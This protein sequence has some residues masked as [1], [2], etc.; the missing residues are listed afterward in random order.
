M[1]QKLNEKFFLTVFAQI[2]IVFLSSCSQGDL[3]IKKTPTLQVQQQVQEEKKSSQMI[4][5]EKI[6]R[7]IS[8]I[9]EAKNLDELMKL[10]DSVNSEW[11]TREIW[12]Y[13]EL[14]FSIC[15]SYQSYDFGN[16]EQY[17]MARKCVKNAL[18]KIEEM[19]VI[20][21][22]KLATLL[23]GNNEYTLGKISISN[24][25]KD[26][27]ERTK[28]WGRAW[29]RFESEIDENFDFEA[30]RPVYHA[31]MTDEERKKAEKYNQQRFLQRDKK[32]FSQA[33]QGYLIEAY[34]KPPYN[35]PEL[36]GFLNKYVKDVGMR[37]SILAE[38]EQKILENQREKQNQ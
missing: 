26:R 28:L 11:R 16:N 33:F 14:M 25:E 35:A 8:Q 31:K 6:L 38:V 23:G 13:T 7:K 20:G 12:F 21:A 36:E 19:P 34:T 22:L 10:E 30:N 32:W 27:T 1:W 18:R 24:W 9:E 17:T 29:Q 37:K 15:G 5:Y 2:I 3:V 4:E